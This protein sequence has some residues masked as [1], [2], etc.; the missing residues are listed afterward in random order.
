MNFKAVIW[1]ILVCI[2][3]QIFA[4]RSLINFNKDWMFFL[5][6]D[7]L[8]RYANYDDAKGHQLA[9]QKDCSRRHL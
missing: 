3:T 9:N 8:A 1:A 2:S 4:Q 5:G 7:S 6:D